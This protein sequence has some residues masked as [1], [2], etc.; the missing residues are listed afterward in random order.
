[1]ASRS[2]DR[3]IRQLYA[4]L[5]TPFSQSSAVDYE[6]IRDH[7]IRLSE[8]GIPDAL[9]T[10]A[11][12][13]F[14]S[15]TDEERY[16]VV[17]SV[18]SVASGSIM[19]C[20]A[21]PSTLHT[22]GL[23]NR[24]LEAGAH[25]IMVAPPLIAEVNDREILRH[26]EVLSKRVEGPL[27]V[28]NNPIFGVDLNRA[29]L[30]E[31]AEF[32]Q[33]TG[34]KQGSTAPDG[35]QVAIE[36]LGARGRQVLAASDLKSVDSLEQGAD[37]LTSTNC[38][39]F[40]NAFRLILE[41]AGTRRHSLAEDLRRALD[42]YVDIVRLLGQPRTVKAAMVLR[43]YEGSAQVRLPYIQLDTDERGLLQVAL[44]RADEQLD[45]VIEHMADSDPSP[46]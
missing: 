28:Y 18:A 32:P 42:P 23:A 4:I 33:I 21:L 20:A 38:S 40:P 35:I 44:D 16:R 25:R 1:M 11:Y 43:G 10:G 5:P 34:L 46:G 31:I 8:A 24:L 41:L 19:A 7:V 29:L 6:A 12:G 36:T 39:I 2:V 37:G 30:A 27:V 45:A 26:F 9:L 3:N 14:Q 13:E 17:S 22:V 15:L